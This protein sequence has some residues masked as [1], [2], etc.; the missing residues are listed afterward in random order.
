MPNGPIG[1]Q[2][3]SGSVSLGS[4]GTVTDAVVVVGGPSAGSPTGNVGFYACQTSSSQT[5]TPGPCAPSVA[6]HLATMRVVPGINNTADAVS[7]AFT[8]PTAG[9]WCFSAVYGG[10]ANYAGASDNT[11]AG[12]LDPSECLLVTSAA[13]TSA[14][15][16]S[17]TSVVL[18]PSGTVTDLVTVSGL[19]GVGAPTGSVAYYVCRTG[20]TQSYTPGICAPGSAIDTEGLVTGAGNTS[21]A[22]SLAFDPT[23]AGTWCFSAVY[24]GDANYTG[25]SDNTSAGNFD[26]SECLL[27]T[28][29]ASSTSTTISSPTITLGPSGTV[30]DAVTVTGNTAGGAPSGSVLFYVCQ[31]AST[32]TLTPGPCTPGTPE[33]TQ[34]LTAGGGDSSTATSVAFTPTAPGTWC[35]SAV[36]GGDTNYT[37]SSDNTSA[38]NQDSGECTLVAQAGSGAT[39]TVSSGTVT[40]GP[41]GSVTDTVTVP[42]NSVGGSPS[43]S[44]VFYVCQIATTQ[45]LTPGP[46]APGTPEDTQGLTAG[47]GNTSTATSVAFDPTAAGTWCFSAVYGGDSNYT[48]SADN[49]S[50]ANA[51]SNE[52]VLVTQAAS[53]SNTT[54]SSGTV[55]LGPSGSVTDAVTVTGNTVGG[56]PT[57]SVVFY[58]C[59]TASSQTLTSGACAPGTPEDTQ[60]LTT[61]PGDTSGATSVAFTPTA[62]GTW[63]F[64]AV[65]GGDSNY[66]GS[67]DNTTAGNLD[68]AECVLVGQAASTTA[69]TVST[70]TVV[71]GPSGTVT[72]AV[73]VT[74]N[75][76]GGAPGG[77]VVFYA[78]HE[79]SSQTLAAGTCA[80]SGSPVDTEGLAASGVNQ[81]SATSGAFTPTAAGTWC[82]GAAYS[83]DSNYT[84]SQDNTNAGNADAN[85]CLLVGQAASTTG[86]AVSAATLILGP[87]GTVTDTVTVNGNA[88]GGSPTGSVAFFACQTSALQTLTTGPCAAVGS[89]QD[90][91]GLVAGVGN[92]AS[93]TSV[94]FTPPSPGTW[95]YSAVYGGDTNYTG[96]EDNTTPANLDAN[97]CV[98]VN[99]LPPMVTV[100]PVTQTVPVGT[101][102]TFSAAATANPSPSVRWQRST[103]GG[104]SWTDIPLATSTSYGT[105]ATLAGSGYEYRAVFTNFGGSTASN[106]AGLAV[107]G[108]TITVSKSAGLIGNLTINIS[109]ASWQT[110][111]DATV[112]IYQCATSVYSVNGCD[113]AN[114]TSAA[115]KTAPVLSVGKFGPQP[116]VL[117]AGVIDAAGDTCGIAGSGACYIVVRGS[118]NDSASA[119][120]TFNVA[121]ASPAKTSAVVGNYVDDPHVV[122]FPVGDTVTTQECDAAVTAATAGAHCD[123]ATVVSAV[124]SSTG[125]VAYASVGPKMLVGNDYSDGAG[126]ACSVGGTCDIVTIDTT[127]P[128]ISMIIPI[129]MVLPKLT[130]TPTTVANGQ[131]KTLSVAATGFPIG[132]PVSAFECDTVFAPASFWDIALLCDNATA[133]TG[134]IPNGSGVVTF[135]NKI[136]TVL[137]SATV[138]AYADVLGGVCKPGDTVGNGDPCHIGAEVPSNNAVVVGTT[139]SI[140]P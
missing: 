116:I 2:V 113:S 91:E 112:N 71:L 87:S 68:A 124:A 19:P 99:A 74:G 85:E 22:T 130:L 82:F 133:I 78:C 122:Y 59:Q 18:G 60:A 64:S 17:V 26:P 32:Q 77:H 65:Y 73:T 4:T 102:V 86:T 80:A 121:N 95:C 129:G 24:G 61:N 58:V 23:A 118:N 83:G 98:F 88:A 131:G 117:H 28:Q 9:T 39:T 110:N 33:D 76:T 139:F 8:P 14:S 11:L 10:D 35:F 15:I 29:A 6:N 57:G 48:G 93:A 7:T 119:A 109:G 126:G 30:T 66:T 114:A 81:S 72:D 45:T 101:P 107:T 36:Y 49:T 31:T 111:G 84:S 34:G 54:V 21:S 132:E 1:S 79:S 135:P 47:A 127:N 108:G 3:S 25:S 89:P 128:A 55:V 100:Q 13:S 16:T 90:T 67:A 27:V 120:L 104:A 62:A 44:V 5:L 138:P 53:A 56:A 106:P 69:T 140:S 70:G 92:T 134:G 12:N 75:A 41:S 50:P 43:G 52:C 96:S 40:L 94:A 42:G 137:S 38:G 123:A 37:G 20:T 115:V 125:A 97:E 51:D 46:C 63:C 103:D 105:T 136:I